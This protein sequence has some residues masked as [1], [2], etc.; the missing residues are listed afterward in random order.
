[1]TVRN[2]KSYTRNAIWN[3]AGLV[4]YEAA[5]WAISMVA[6]RFAGYETAGIW[7][8]TMSI[9]NIFYMIA[10]FQLAAFMVADVENSIPAGKIL[11]TQAFMSLAALLACFVYCLCFGYPGSTLKPVLAYM[12]FRLTAA[13][14]D[15]LHGLYRRH[16]SLKYAGTANILRGLLSLAAFTVSVWKLGDLTAAFLVMTAASLAILFYEYRRAF[17]LEPCRP[18]FDF[19]AIRDLIRKLLP[20]VLSFSFINAIA[21][22]PRQKLL[23]L[24]GSAALGYYGSVATVGVAVTVV[25]N[26]TF[27]TVMR[28]YAMQK[29]D[30][31]ATLRLLFRCLLLLAGLTVLASLCAVFLGEWGLSILYGDGIRPYASLLVPVVLTAVFNAGSTLLMNLCLI[32]N[33][34]WELLFTSVLAIP[35]CSFLAEPLIGR[36]GLNGLSWCITLTYG[37]VIAVLFIALMRRIGGKKEEAQ[38]EK[39]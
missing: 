17:S 4:I 8:L 15:T 14:G 30:R 35:I 18:S 2:R 24:Q 29:D 22:I 25:A 6:V 32:F 7:Q 39:T 37:F 28:D 5:M 13:H 19:K 3:V 38:Y 26:G 10:T 11:G 20:V 27:E 1:M 9:T 23:A 12:L 16:Y 31:K 33:T 36:F 34:R 21:T